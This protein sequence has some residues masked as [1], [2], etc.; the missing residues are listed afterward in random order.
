MPADTFVLLGAFISVSGR[1]DPW[2]VFFAVWVPN[3]TAALLVY[4]LSRRFGPSFL[5]SPFGRWLLRPRHLEDIGRF[6]DRWGVPAIFVGRFVPAFRAVVPA[7]AGISG[8]SLWRVLLPVAASSAIWYGTLVLLGAT[9]GRDVDAIV[10][11]F[12]QMGGVL[13]WIASICF[14]LV[15]V[16]WVRTRRRQA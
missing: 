11:T 10:A 5:G 3:V 9:A 1:A 15:L 6:Y 13:V 2:A 8:V 16:W 4:A 14:V 12:A 7:F